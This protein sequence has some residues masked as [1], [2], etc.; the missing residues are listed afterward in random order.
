M[1]DKKFKKAVVISIISL[2]FSIA[3]LIIDIII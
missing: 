2:L 1:E 3:A